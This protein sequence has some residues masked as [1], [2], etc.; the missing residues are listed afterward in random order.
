M[1]EAIEGIE[2]QVHII[3]VNVALDPMQEGEEAERR[4]VVDTLVA[5]KTQLEDYITVERSQTRS[6]VPAS[7]SSSSTSGGGFPP[8]SS[9]TCPRATIRIAAPWERGHWLS[10]AFVGKRVRRIGPPEGEPRNMSYTA[11]VYVLM[12]EIGS[13]WVLSDDMQRPDS[14][15]QPGHY[16]HGILDDDR[17]Q[18]VEPL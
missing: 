16:V 12:H 8:P 9:G 13:N 17:W 3:R 4:L 11:G 1:E 7:S 10:A 6:F 18:I 14:I 15:L 5:E 2:E